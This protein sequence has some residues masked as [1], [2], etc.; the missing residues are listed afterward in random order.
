MFAKTRRWTTAAALGAAVVV[1]CAATETLAI[2]RSARSVTANTFNSGSVVIT[3]GPTTALLAV[4]GMMPGDSVTKALQVTNGGVPMR[5]A[6]SSTATNPDT[7]GLK[8]QLALTIKAVDV[9]TPATPCD[10][11]DGA[12]LYSGDLDSASGKLIGDIAQGNQ[13]GDRTLAAGTS[14]YLCFRVAL[15]IGAS[16]TYMLT[17]TTAT[18]TFGAEQTANNP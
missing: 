3:T 12:T 9:T 5:Y 14:E 2:F 11:F 6:I 13:A 8:D 7:K 15:P 10:N 16:S 17:T 1:A 18:F 4:S